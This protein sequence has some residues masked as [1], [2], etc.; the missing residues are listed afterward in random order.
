MNAEELRADVLRELKVVAPF[1]VN[2]E[3]EA[4]RFP[5]THHIATTLCATMLRGIAEEEVDREL[6]PVRWVDALLLALPRWVRRLLPPARMRAI[7]TQILR[8]RTCPHLPKAAAEKHLWHL[9]DPN[10]VG[11]P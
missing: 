6:V 1:L 7:P 2:P 5:A 11:L 10:D 3:I 9:L 8:Y 4:A